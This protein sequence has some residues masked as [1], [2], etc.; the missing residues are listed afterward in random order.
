MSQ[1][2]ASKEYAAPLKFRAYPLEHIFLCLCLAAGCI[3]IA[4]FVATIYHD[5]FLLLMLGISGTLMIIPV[6]LFLGYPVLIV[7]ADTD[8][9]ELLIELV[10]FLGKG[11]YTQTVTVD[12][13]WKIVYS[14]KTKVQRNSRSGSTKSSFYIDIRDGKYVYLCPKNR[15][16]PLSSRMIGR[17][18]KKELNKPFVIRKQHSNYG[19]QEKEVGES[20]ES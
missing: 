5:Y 16:Y 17:K 12:K 7:S 14:V 8:R 19:M 1:G 2:Q 9:K 20:I 10:T 11:T 13:V 3:A 18:L 4:V 6:W 15:A